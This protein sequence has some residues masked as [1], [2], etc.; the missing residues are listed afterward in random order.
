MKD[1]GECPKCGTGEVSTCEVRM[2]GGGISRFVDVQTNVFD[3]VS[4]DECGYT[5][6]YRKDRDSKSEVLD[7]FLGG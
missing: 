6:F 1:E 7:F 3:A 5:E 2:T 4:C